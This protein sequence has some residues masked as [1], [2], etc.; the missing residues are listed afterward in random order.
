MQLEEVSSK[1]VHTGS[2]DTALAG[3]ETCALHDI[4]RPFS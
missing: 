3:M 4:N 2:E 1:V